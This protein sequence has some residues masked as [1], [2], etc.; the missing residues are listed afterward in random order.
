MR[1]L[2]F[3]LLKGIFKLFKNVPIISNSSSAVSDL[4]ILDAYH[5]ILIGI[6]DLLVVKKWKAIMIISTL[7]AI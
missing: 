5:L 1:V 7:C 4:P 6:A 2:I 3:A